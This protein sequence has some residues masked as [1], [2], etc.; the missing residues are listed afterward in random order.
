M[1]EKRAC[2]VCY[3]EA[4]VPCRNGEG[5]SA[6]LCMTC[7]GK[8]FM[9][10]QDKC[11]ICRRLFF[12]P[13]FSK[14][15]TPGTRYTRKYWSFNFGVSSVEVRMLPNGQAMVM[16]N[17]RDT[18][19]SKMEEYACDMGVL[20]GEISDDETISLVL[21]KFDGNAIVLDDRE[22][23]DYLRMQFVAM[24]MSFVYLDGTYDFFKLQGKDFKRFIKEGRFF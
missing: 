14:L 10:G 20:Q 4:N 11:P 3:E 23:F 18:S 12:N 9:L 7:I 22:D 13:E 5:C 6:F 8:M 1:S 2:C 21:S 24:G 15:Y 16:D 17:C 19:L